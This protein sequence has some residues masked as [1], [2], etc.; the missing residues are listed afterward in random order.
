MPVSSSTVTL[1]QPVS[2]QNINDTYSTNI[3]SALHI[4][5]AQKFEL[6]SSR[7]F[8][9]TFNMNPAIRSLVRSKKFASDFDGP[10]RWNYHVF[11]SFQT[12]DFK[13]DFEICKSYSFR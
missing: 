10:N 4:V 5:N 7:N 2:L 6:I 1:K 8:P 3:L 9:R 13:Y 12:V 11:E